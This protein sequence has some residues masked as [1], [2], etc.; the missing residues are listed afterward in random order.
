MHSSHDL[1]HHYLA[2][3]E[4]APQVR[5]TDSVGKTV[6]KT[7]LPLTSRCLDSINIRGIG[8]RGQKGFALFDASSRLKELHERERI[9]LLKEKDCRTRQLH[10]IHTTSQLNGRSGSSFSLASN[11]Y[12]AG[13][14][15]GAFTLTIR[16]GASPP[17]NFSESVMLYLSSHRVR[18][19]PPTW[20]KT[21]LQW[22]RFLSI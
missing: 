14:V 12:P 18:M 19:L 13:R 1:C 6:T 2:A 7:I 4:S 20:L 17:I 16:G 21:L 22:R 5:V 11:V 3:T 10:E 9:S 15:A 8:D